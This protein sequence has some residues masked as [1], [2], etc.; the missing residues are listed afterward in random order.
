[1]HPF[2]APKSAKNIAKKNRK[3]VSLI[4]PEFLAIRGKPGPRYNPRGI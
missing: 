1:M 4:A 3:S 2:Y